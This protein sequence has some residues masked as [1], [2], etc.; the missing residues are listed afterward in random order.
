MRDTADGAEFGMDQP[1][2]ALQPGIAEIILNHFAEELPANDPGR[3]F[4]EAYVRMREIAQVA[5]WMHRGTPPATEFKPGAREELL[6]GTKD[7]PTFAE[8]Q[9][10]KGILNVTG[11]A[12]QQALELDDAPSKGWIRRHAPAR[13]PHASLARGYVQ[14]LYD[15]ANVETPD[16]ILLI[17]M[18]AGELE[19]IVPKALHIHD[20]EFLN[21]AID[22]AVQ[23]RYLQSATDLEQR[24]E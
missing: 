15:R 22:L 5:R 19:K 21:D 11:I 6:V 18:L 20:M 24:M 2:H 7:S 3:I 12:L 13:G 17:T 10:L 4:L 8:P 16:A 1:E 9:G 23:Q 14:S